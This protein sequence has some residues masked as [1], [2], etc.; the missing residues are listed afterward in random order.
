MAAGSTYTPIATQTLSGTQASV[1]F[2]S[3][4]SAY[5][6]LILTVNGLAYYPSS[7]YANIGLQFNSDS[8]S[9]YS[10]TRVYGTGSS[11]ASQTYANETSIRSGY[12]QCEPS[13]TNERSIILLNVQNYSNTTT[14]KTILSRNGGASN[15]TGANVG[16]WRS[17]S[18]ISS[19]YLFNRDSATG[20]LAGTFTLYGVLNA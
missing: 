1:T 6:D 16:L 9:N 7:N 10:T 20:F 12:M 18:A 15:W 4:S 13:L 14:Y 11:T 17:T 5:T 2:N 19:I 8:G 3:I